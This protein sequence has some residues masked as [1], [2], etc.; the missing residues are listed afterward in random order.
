MRPDLLARAGKSELM[1][2]LAGDMSESG[3]IVRDN[4]VGEWRA[5]PLPLHAEGHLQ[6]LNLYVHRDP[7]QSER[8]SGNA[9]GSGSVRFVI[10]MRMSRLGAMQLDGLV[11]P[12]KLDMIVRSEHTLPPG[13]PNELRSSYSRTLDALG[14]TGGLSFQLGR[15]HW[16]VIQRETPKPVLL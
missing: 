7:R 16:L 4:V 10:D 13:L 6:M 1:A 5:Y 15:H 9:P 12:K 3:H 2:R 11:Q 14:Y 8:G